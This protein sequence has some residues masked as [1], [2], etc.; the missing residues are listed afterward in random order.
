MRLLRLP[1]ALVPAIV[2]FPLLGP[3]RSAQ[4][5][6]ADFASFMEELWLDAQAKGIT[7]RTLDTAFAGLTPDPRVIAATQR[8]PEYGKPVGAYV[9]AVASKARIAEGA[10]KAAQWAGTFAA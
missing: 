5:E 4:A 2:L 6:N 8:Q 9:N 10:A 7:R 3:L 1:I